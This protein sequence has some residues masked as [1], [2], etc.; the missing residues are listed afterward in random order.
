MGPNEFEESGEFQGVGKVTIRHVID[1]IQPH[2]QGVYTCVGQARDQIMASDPVAISVEGISYLYNIY[3][4]NYIHS[5]HTYK[6]YNYI[7]LYVLL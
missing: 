5:K 4:L 6:L 2:H 7:I 1:C 3:F